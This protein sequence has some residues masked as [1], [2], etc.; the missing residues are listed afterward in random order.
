[1]AFLTFFFA[2]LFYIAT[3]VL[4]GGVVFRIYIYWKTP[5][6]LKIP[7]TPAPTSR[8][9]V[10][11]RLSREVVLFESLF[12]ANKPTW[13]LGWLF[14][15]G[16]L[17]VLLRHIR[18]FQEPVWW[19][20]SLIQPAGKYAA[21]AMV[22]GLVGLW[23][24]RLV[25]DRVRYISAP[26]DHLMLALLIGIGASG[27]LMSFVTRTDIVAVK[28]FFL[29]L[30][31]FDWQLL[32]ADFVLIVHLLLVAALMIVFPFSKLLH[33]PGIFFSPTRNQVDN[34]RERRHLAPW[35]AA[36]RTGR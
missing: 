7:T 2:L 31:V 28:A 32:P 13:L 25:V 34:P 33:A 3:A 12:K 10:V 30:M 24:R 26:S 15:F 17:L 4:V 5:A 35:A 36:G 22:F 8:S 14:H 6:P 27:M 29:G 16:L 20:V 19:W 11:W 18:Y 9:G 21:Y 23:I 1:M